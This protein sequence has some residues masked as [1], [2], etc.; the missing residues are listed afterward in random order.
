M[1]SKRLAYYRRGPRKGNHHFQKPRICRS[2]FIPLAGCWPGC[3]IVGFRKIRLEASFA[4][5]GFETFWS[6]GLWCST[7]VFSILSSAF[8]AR[9]GGLSRS[10]TSFRLGFRVYDRSR[11]RIKQQRLRDVSAALRQGSMLK[12]KR[13]SSPEPCQSCS[14]SVCNVGA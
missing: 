8:G 13:T 6:S 11:G 9:V 2:S 3:R 7:S 10:F 1:G 4:G 12:F 14:S 5:A